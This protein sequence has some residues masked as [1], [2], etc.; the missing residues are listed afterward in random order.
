MYMTSI[1]PINPGF[2]EGDQ[3]VLALGSHQGTCGVFLRIRESG[4]WAD[5]TENNGQV[6]HHP[7]AW[8]AHAPSASTTSRR[9]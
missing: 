2:R 6:R 7:L 3:V 5:I 1:R 4:D 8:L 9:Q